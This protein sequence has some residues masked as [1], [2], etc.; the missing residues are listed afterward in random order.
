MAVTMR[1]APA[2][3]ACQETQ[4]PSTLDDRYVP[5]ARTAASTFER[6]AIDLRHRAFPELA[7]ARRACGGRV[8]AGWRAAASV[9]MPHLDRLTVA[10]FQS[11]IAAILGTLA[12][13]LGSA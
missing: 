5:S 9:A 8:L 1:A 10:E 12:D 6:V 11:S 4:T 7:G 3:I 2:A 13:A